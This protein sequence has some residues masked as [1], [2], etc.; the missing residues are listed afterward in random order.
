[1]PYYEREVIQPPN[2]IGKH[3]ETAKHIHAEYGQCVF[4]EKACLGAMSR[5]GLRRL[6]SSGPSDISIMSKNK[7]EK[8][9][10]RTKV[11][12][13]GIKANL[14]TDQFDEPALNMI[15]SCVLSRCDRLLTEFQNHVLDCAAIIGSK[16]SL[17]TIM[18]LMKALSRS[19]SEQRMVA[20]SN[21]SDSK[22]EIDMMSGLFTIDDVRHCLWV[23]VQ[24]QFIV[25]CFGSDNSIGESPE[26]RGE[27]RRMSSEPHVAFEDNSEQENNVYT[28]HVQ[29]VHTIIYNRT[30]GEMRR[31]MLEVAE[32][33][34]EDLNGPKSDYWR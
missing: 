2:Y 30:L 26:Q 3:N 13:K 25:P 23:L 7:S 4:N 20:T 8:S 28:W 11:S 34:R 27:V 19:R 29:M 21:S 22:I 18:L 14:Q 10:R 32:T 15:E 5:G 9:K 33:Y 6:T 16:F 1:M 24:Y 31:K 12:A 17:R